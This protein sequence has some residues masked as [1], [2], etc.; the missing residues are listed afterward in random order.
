MTLTLDTYQLQVMLNAAAE[1]GAKKALVVAGLEKTQ[2]SKAE[3]YRRY[4]RRRVDR[5]VKEHKVTLIKDNGSTLLNLDEL[6]AISQIEN[7]ISK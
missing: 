3:A 4:T 1:M 7:I 6:E 5:W 2:V